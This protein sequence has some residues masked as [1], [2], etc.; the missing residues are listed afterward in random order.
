MGKLYRGCVEGFSHDGRGIV[1]LEDKVFFVPGALP[2][3][4]IEFESQRKR[5][6]QFI[7]KLNKI[8]RASPHRVIPD[9]EYFGICGG[10]TLQHLS[11]EQQIIY[12]EKTLLDTLHRIGDV[13]PENVLPTIS[14]ETWYYRRR[15]RPGVKFVPKKGGIL[16][17]FREQGTS[18]LTSLKNCKTLDRRL[19][20]LLGPLHNLVAKLSCYGQVPQI[21][22]AAADNAIAM[23]M[24]HLQP[25]ID[26]DRDLLELFAQRHEI[27]LF[28]Q[29]GGLDSIVPL[30]P[31]NPEPLY[32]ELPDLGLR[33]EFSATDFVQING[34]VNQTLINRVLN[35][36][37]PG[38]G[39]RILD[40]FCG[41]G[42]FTLPLAVSGAEVLGVEGD[43]NLVIKGRQNAELNRV[44]NVAFQQMDLFSDS[45][46][47]LNSM[48]F[49]KMLL[50]PP[51]SGALKVVT[52]LVPHIF[53]QRI[54][55]VSCNPAT[56]SRDAEIL[57]HHH[58][59]R[60]T[61]AGAID[62]FPHTAHVESFGVFEKSLDH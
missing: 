24:R 16:I 33:I 13:V 37:N 38:P 44:Q 48:E 30:W 25:L 32:Y 50:D 49:T 3:E 5:R 53:P 62:M 60:L 26:T 39:D 19:S 52:E 56:F 35:F 17:G 40:L 34:E 43:Q 14:G 6:G 41:L 58:G 47:N 15:A 8:E 42:N 31:P 9:C 2:N 28:L 23:V 36:I 55:Y 20:A 22:F 21:E 11:P 51:R 46:I 1:K 57:T 7:G 61:H 45:T 54:V 59:Y 18:Y 27:Q 29:P 4:T 10:C 12:K